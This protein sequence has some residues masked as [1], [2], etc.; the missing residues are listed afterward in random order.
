[1]KDIKQES[2]MTVQDFYSGFNLDFLSEEERQTI[3]TATELYAKGKLLQYGKEWVSV[4]ERTPEVPEGKDNSENVFAIC[5]SRLRIMAYCYIEMGEDSGWAWCDCNGDIHGDPEF[6]GD[7]K[8]THWMPLP[9][10]PKPK[11]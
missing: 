8:V 3:Y 7:Y 9:E 11:P 6:D 5:G 10:L 4:E 2:D 1:M